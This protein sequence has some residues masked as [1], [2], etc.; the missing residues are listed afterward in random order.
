[1][2]RILDL[3][4][5]DGKLAVLLD[6]PETDEGSVTVWTE[7]EKDAA[8]ERVRHAERSECGRIAAEYGGQAAD[9]I[10]EQIM[11]RSFPG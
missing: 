9:E 10:A 5:V 4:T 3:K 8:F 2:P 6:M 1:M 7:A 11:R